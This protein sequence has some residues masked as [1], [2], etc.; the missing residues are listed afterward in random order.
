MAKEEKRK[1]RGKKGG[2][3]S[4]FIKFL[5]FLFACVIILI[6][7]SIGVVMY[8]NNSVH[9]KTSDIVISE[10]DGIR[11][12]DDGS[13]LI[14]IRRGETSQSV[15]SRL[16][17]TGFISNRYVWNLFCRFNNQHLKTGTYKIEL[18]A[19][20]ISIYSLLVSGREVL[21]R[22]TIPE[23]VTIRKASII[24]EQA[25]ICSAD[26]F[27]NAARNPQIAGDFGIPGNSMEGY[28]FPD[29]Y[30]FP[31]AY[32]AE[33]AVRKM[34]DTFFRNLAN[35]NPS[36]TGLSPQE[37]NEKVI[38]AS[39]VEREYRIADEAPLIAGVFNNRLEINMALQSC[40][41]VQYVITEILGQ[42]H[43]HV[44][45]FRDLEIRNPYNT[46]LYRGLP[47]GPISAPGFV[48]LRAVMNPA[49]T[50]FLYFRLLDASSGRHTF[51]RT[52]NEHM[53]A[54]DLYIKP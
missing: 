33:L 11:K 28:L 15:G 54:G 38:L 22:V 45:L 36:F 7:V 42:P 52:Y 37:L 25:G 26:E 18:P 10:N 13:F 47:P 12:A 29:T 5:T 30:F 51:S 6:P 20:M 19:S 53:R 16:E 31:S 27:L 14:D 35:I 50:D 40:A 44:L 32:P 34:A 2:L 49:S 24:I 17:R 1:K 39:I 23:G 41:T 3:F 8:F 43:P 9:S 46:Y 4:F 48:A 21:H